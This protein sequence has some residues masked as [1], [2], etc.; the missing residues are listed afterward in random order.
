M[1]PDGRRRLLVPSFALWRRAFAS[2][3]A[4]RD[5]LKH[6]LTSTQEALI[7]LRGE[8]REL[9]AAVLAST[10]QSQNWRS[11]IANARSHEPEP[12][13]ATRTRC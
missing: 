5:A 8:L 11:C 3:V 7:A 9:R 2:I 10:K 4:E 12:P 6:E 13:S 1:W